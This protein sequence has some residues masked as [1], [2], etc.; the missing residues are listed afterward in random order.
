MLKKSAI[1]AA[2]AA[3]FM[4]IGSPAFATQGAWDEGGDTGQLGLLNVDDVANDN[5]VGV[6]DNNVNVLGV[7]V[8]DALEGVGATVPILSGASDAQSGDAPDT[9]V[10][11]A[12]N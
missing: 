7:Q 3:G 5:N 2:A 6:C 1:V 8:A 9:C 10:A 11:E 12:D 4:M